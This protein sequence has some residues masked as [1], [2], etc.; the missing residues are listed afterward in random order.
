MAAVATVAEVKKPKRTEQAA[1]TELPKT[2]KTLQ[3]GLKSLT[4]A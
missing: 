2:T 4:T 3:A 1:R